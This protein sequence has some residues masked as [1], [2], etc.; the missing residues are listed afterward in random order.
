MTGGKWQPKKPR[1]QAKCYRTSRQ[2][3]DGGIKMSRVEDRITEEQVDL[4]VSAK[5]QF[6]LVTRVIAECAGMKT[7]SL[8]AV[9]NKSRYATKFEYER[10]YNIMI[11]LI[12]EKMGLAAHEAN[13][14][15]RAMKERERRKEQA[16]L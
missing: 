13:V 2:Q 7:S 9:F 8:N 1:H 4:L 15:I 11:D 16:G 10:I 5:K 6:G 14:R 12:L 3:S